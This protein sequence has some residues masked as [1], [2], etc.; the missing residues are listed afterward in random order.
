MDVEGEG[1]MLGRMMMHM[2]V[3]S[4]TL[5]GNVQYVRSSSFTLN[6]WFWLWLTQHR[7]SGPTGIPPKFG[8]SRGSDH[9]L[10]IKPTIYLKRGKGTIVHYTVTSYNRL[11][12]E[13]WSFSTDA[14]LQPS[15][16]LFDSLGN[17]YDTVSHQPTCSPV[18]A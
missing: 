5:D 17:D 6:A 11:M 9:F 13:M 2:G 10:S 18:V 4:H 16:S 15:P 1:M 14:G 3:N 12:L 7:R 8:C